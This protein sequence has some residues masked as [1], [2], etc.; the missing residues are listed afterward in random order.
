MNFAKK[1]G[2]Y[3]LLSVLLVFVYPL[4]VFFPTGNQ[5]IYF[6]WGLNNAGYGFFENDFLASQSDPFPLFS[7]LVAKFYFLFGKNIFLFLYWLLNLVYVSAFFETVEAVIEKQGLKKS[8][9]IEKAALF[10]FFHSTLIWG[11][12]F[13]RFF[14]FDL[15]WVW[16]S[17]F[18]EQGILRG[19]LQ[20]SVFGVL[21]FFSAALFFGRKYIFAFVF[22]ALAACFHANYFLV[23]AV[24]IA[25]YFTC[26][27]KEKQFKIAF[28]GAAI[29]FLIVLPY[30]IYTFK[31]F[32]YTSPETAEHIR[33]NIEGHIHF[34][35]KMWMNGKALLQFMLIV[36]ALWLTRKTDFFLPLVTTFSILLF[37]TA[38]TY[39]LDS[40]FLLILTPWRISVVLV[41]PALAVVLAFVFSSE[42]IQIRKLF[43]SVIFTFALSALWFR[44]FGNSSPEYLIKW[45]VFTA[46]LF[47]L[48]SAVFYFSEKYFSPQVYMK[49]V[50]LK[51][52]LL[53]LLLGL[54]GIFLHPKDRKYE[55]ELFAFAKKNSSPGQLY[56]IPPD[57]LEFRLSAGVSVFADSSVHH[58][59]SLPERDKRLKTINRI[60]QQ[61]DTAAL[62]SLAKIHGI[63]HIIAKNETRFM[64]GKE[65]Y[66]NRLYAIFEL[67]E[68]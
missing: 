7:W 11:F 8:S 14:N 4:D 2:S 18:A 37:L 51:A 21:I 32:G 13:S 53:L 17:G 43:F 62:D 59:N 39:F 61:N 38:F 12:F 34:D 52:I 42:N 9:L 31:N 57:L 20:P 24:F 3:L 6:F 65:I 58:G 5:C 36:F 22:A 60:F 25:V 29:S 54:S 41:P 23:S 47:I 40:V 15:R 49:I 27:I 26:L 30:L 68:H 16:D 44:I 33:N 35:Y 55:A 67:D 66:R 50:S 63:T 45:R 10:L 19:Y 46:L 56:L 48:I 1:A 64:A 28:L